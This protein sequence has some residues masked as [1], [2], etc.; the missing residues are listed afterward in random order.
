MLTPDQFSDKRLKQLYQNGVVRGLNNDWLPK[1]KR[2]LAA[3]AVAVDPKDLDMPGSHWHQ[4]K[5]NRSDTYSV[6]V[7]GNWRLTYRWIDNGPANVKLEDYH[8]N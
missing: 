3:L 8:G 1:I 6:R 5:G 7:S 4:L 2:Y